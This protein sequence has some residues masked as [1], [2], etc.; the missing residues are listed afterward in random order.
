MKYDKKMPIELADHAQSEILRALKRDLPESQ[1]LRVWGDCQSNE[2]LVGLELVC[3]EEEVYYKQ[4]VG[5]RGEE[6]AEDENDCFPLLLDAASALFI[7]FH[8][9]EWLN[10]LPIEWCEMPFAGQTIRVRAEFRRPKL[11]QMANAW[12]EKGGA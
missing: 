5:Y 11:E 3:S 7:R 2:W 8:D 6:S 10:P 1:S 4:E 9:E 12:L